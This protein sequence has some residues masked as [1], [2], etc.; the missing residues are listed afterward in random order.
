MSYCSDNQFPTDTRLAD[1]RDFLLLLGYRKLSGWVTFEDVSFESYGWH[2][3]EDHKSWSGVELSINNKGGRLS[4]STRTPVSRS[5]YDLEQQN[6][7]ISALRKRFGGTFRTDAGNGRY[8][9][10]EFGPP[11]PAASGC[12][13]AFSRFGSNLIRASHYAQSLVFPHHPPRK[14]DDIIVQ[15]GMHPQTLSGNMLMSF[16]VSIVEDYLKSCFIALLRYSPQKEQFLRGA[17]LNGD[18][19]NRISNR[20][21]SVEQAVAETFSFQRIS[22]ACK[23]FQSL[24]RKLDLASV[25]RKP[26]RRRRKTLY[27]TLEELVD[28]RNEFVHRAILDLGLTDDVVRE[29]LYDLEVAMTRVQRAIVNRYNW[30]YEKTWHV[31]RPSKAT[32]PKAASGTTDQL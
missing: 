31:G 11:P 17:R 16:S 23:N 13:L 2:D 3:T 32:R 8:Q 30:P 1:I 14:S 12:H 22:T 4:V 24:D 21:Y 15:L 25:L 27:D 29:A 20:E 10:A 9:R 26:F 6:R 18:Q 7:T 19:L 28:K 5:Y